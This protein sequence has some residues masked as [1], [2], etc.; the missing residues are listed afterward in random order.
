MRPH[1]GGSRPSRDGCGPRT[2]PRRPP[3][4]PRRP[5]G[6]RQLRL[7]QG[8]SAYAVRK[9]SRRLGEPAGRARSGHGGARR[10]R[11][12]AACPPRRAR[13]V[14]GEA[15]GQRLGR[16][17]LEVDDLP[18]L[19]A[20][21]GSGPD[22][23]RRAPAGWRAG[24]RRAWRRRT[25]ARGV[26]VVQGGR[27]LGGRGQP[28]V[29]DRLGDGA[30]DV[31]R[32]GRRRAAPR[33]SRRGPG[34]AAAASSAKSPSVAQRVQG[35]APAVL[36]PGELLHRHARDRPRPACRP[37]AS[38]PGSSRRVGRRR[39][40]RRGPVRRAPRCRGWGRARSGGR[41]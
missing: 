12:S 14:R 40:P 27:D 1:R 11:T 3:C 22:G 17:A 32:S 16:L 13:R 30:V 38:G 5:A 24:R 41:T 39:R 25:A 34:R 4:P 33:G 31:G 35:Q 23:S 36:G 8:P 28:A 29:H 10:S 15:L 2:P 21:S 26:T 19:A 9:A 7:G 18:A 20:S 37:A 6:S